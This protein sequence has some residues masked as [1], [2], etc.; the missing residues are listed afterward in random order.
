[1][2]QKR[3][4]IHERTVREWIKE[5][6]AE[7]VESFFPHERNRVYSTEEKL[8]AVRAYQVG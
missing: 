7:G 2:P 3:N 6:A 5:Y 8:E 1:M 4:K